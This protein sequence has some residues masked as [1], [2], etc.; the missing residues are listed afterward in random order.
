MNALP[1]TPFDVELRDSAG[2]VIAGATF[3]VLRRGD[4]LPYHP[5][6]PEALIRAFQD[7]G[8][9]NE[10]RELGPEAAHWPRLAPLVEDV[11]NRHAGGE[12]PRIERDF[13][14]V[15]AALVETTLDLAEQAGV[16]SFAQGLEAASEF[17]LSDDAT[18]LCVIAARVAG[19]RVDVANVQHLT[20]EAIKE[21]HTASIIRARVLLENRPPVAF[22]LNVARDATAAAKRLAALAADLRAWHSIDSHAAA[23]VLDEETGQIRFFGGE[24]QI[25]IVVTSWI[26]ADELHV[27]RDALHRVLEFVPGSA[28]AVPGIRGEV[29]DEDACTRVIAATASLRTRLVTFGNSEVCERE[30]ELNNGD[31]VID[32]TFAP[33]LVGSAARTWRGPIGAWPYRL[34]GLSARDEHA[35]VARRIWLGRSAAALVA[36]LAA[37]PSELR[38]A[39]C[40]AALHFDPTELLQELPP[41]ARDAVV[42]AVRE[43]VL[44]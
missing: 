43:E 10:R 44:R 9:V 5:I 16:R 25:P 12:R 30:H 31:V 36:G 41:T 1:F 24:R 29:L 40:D 2:P 37:V 22:V 33:I 19:E 13:A 39:M 17:L 15:P 14:H 27:T 42:A 3:D 18:R 21:G 32:R 20:L 38:A 26:E 23:E 28:S 4:R 35:A 6:L 11:W 34:A 8:W 7:V